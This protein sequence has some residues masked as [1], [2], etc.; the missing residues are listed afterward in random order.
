MEMNEDEEGD[1]ELK[2]AIR[3]READKIMMTR[4]TR[5]GSSVFCKYFSNPPSDRNLGKENLYDFIEK[6][7]E[8]FLVQYALGVK[9]DEMR[10]LEEIAQ[11]RE[12]VH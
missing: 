2:E 12:I 7:R 5:G 11:V 9:R 6:K 3:K 10:K 4:Q 1:N 8:M